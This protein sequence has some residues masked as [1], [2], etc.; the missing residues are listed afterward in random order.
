MIE[1]WVLFVILA[2]L[3]WCCG[4]IIDKHVF[5]NYI[6]RPIIGTIVFSIIGLIFSLSIFSYNFDLMP[7][8]HIALSFMV[9]FL[10]IFGIY[11]YLKSLTIE[12]LSRVI[13]LFYFAPIFTLILATIFLGEMFVPLQYL[14]IAL[15]I[16]GAILISIRF[17]Q[18]ITFSK[19]FWFM[20]GSALSVSIGTVTIRYLI[21]QGENFL[22]IFAYTRLGLFIFMIPLLLLYASQF[23]RIIK[24]H[25]K[26]VVA[27]MSV[28]STFNLGASIAV[29]AALS[30]TAGYASLVSALTSVQP[31]FILII[32]TL[33]SFYYPKILHEE[34]KGSIIALKAAAIALIVIGAFLVM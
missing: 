26:K 31:L 23:R 24:T 19:A 7:P 6:K 34:I 29:F 32:A 14:G 11:L 5:S 2:T 30:F 3:L 27:F 12:E 28:S 22:T 13:P 8:L 10:F 17:G 9:G 33:I 20:I 25:G 15:L 4:N 18:S 16:S 1:M 21:T